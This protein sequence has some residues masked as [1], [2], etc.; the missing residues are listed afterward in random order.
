L[1][2]FQGPGK[3]I[4]QTYRARADHERSHGWH[5]FTA[6]GVGLARP[7]S[8]SGLPASAALADSRPPDLPALA[9]RYASAQSR[10]RAVAGS[11][12]AMVAGWL[13]TGNH[14]NFKLLI[15]RLS[16]CPPSA[17]QKRPHYWV[18]FMDR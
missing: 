2:R 3:L 12:A 1:V 14:A 5:R 4:G 17:S 16:L 10:E 9:P 18:F 8:G 13:L 11:P 6:E 7:S 15:G